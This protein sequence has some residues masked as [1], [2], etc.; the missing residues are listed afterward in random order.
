MH[1]EK[2]GE[3]TFMQ[4]RWKIMQMQKMYKKTD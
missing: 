2:Q 1:I 4:Y 3:D